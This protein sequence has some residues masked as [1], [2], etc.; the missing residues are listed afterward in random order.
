MGRFYMA[1]FMK[2]IIIVKL[3]LGITPSPSGEGM[4]G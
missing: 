3:Y 1:S 2:E 4:Q